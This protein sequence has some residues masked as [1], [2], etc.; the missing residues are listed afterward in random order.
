MGGSSRNYDSYEKNKNVID[1]PPPSTPPGGIICMETETGKEN[2]Y[3]KRIA[4]LEIRLINR[5]ETRIKYQAA[6]NHI[7]VMIKSG[8]F[9]ANDALGIIDEVLED[10]TVKFI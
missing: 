4:F 2:W 3:K 7:A 10:A 9:N 1:P 5:S 8:K 6:L